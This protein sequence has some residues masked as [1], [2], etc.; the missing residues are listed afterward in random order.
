MSLAGALDIA[1]LSDSGRVR[2]HNEDSFASN[3]EIG[4]IVLA[5]GMGG[6]SAGEVASAVAVTRVYTETRDA[7]TTLVP[8]QTDPESGLRYESVILGD[9]I[10]RA[11]EEI[12]STADENREF[13]GMGTTI[14]CALFYD[15][16]LTC[17]HAGDSRMYRL[18]EGRLEQMTVDHTVVQEVVDGGM[19]TRD[20]A[21]EAFNPSLVTRALGAD[22]N[23]T[24]D[25]NECK[26]ITGDLF[27][28]C[29]D[30]LTNMVEEAAIARILSEPG[31]LDTAAE[32]LV[33]LANRNGGEDNITVALIRVVDDF[34]AKGNWQTQ[35]LNL[36]NP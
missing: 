35:M 36:L 25:I 5:D 10:R 1:G 24:A 22:R 3:S 20:E 4:L 8:G 21:R 12:F 27:M 28:L 23:L 11:N 26:V 19:I 14:V 33:S 16:R 29:S 30:G 9:A 6:Y 32:R 2:P 17:A 7:L 31:G 34:K 18:R 15:N 13:S